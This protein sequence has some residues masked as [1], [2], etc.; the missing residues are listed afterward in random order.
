MENFDAVG[1]WRDLDNGNAIDASGTFPD[2]TKFAGM[3]GLKAALLSHPEEFVLTLPQLFFLRSHLHKKLNHA[4]PYA[5]LQKT[6]TFF[7]L[8]R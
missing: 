5:T 4:A 1:R 2:G 3:A 6:R 8:R 7:F